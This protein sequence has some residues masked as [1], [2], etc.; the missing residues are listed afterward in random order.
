M[1]L[2]E[3]Y[4]IKFPKA[5]LW[6]DQVPLFF[7]KDLK[8]SINEVT[9]ETKTLTEFDKGESQTITLE[10]DGFVMGE[11]RD[12]LI[13]K[14]PNACSYFKSKKAKLVVYYGRTDWMGEGGE[15]QG[16]QVED[17]GDMF[18]WWRVEDIG[19]FNGILINI[20]NYET[21][22][23]KIDLDV[24]DKYFDKESKDRNLNIPVAKLILTFN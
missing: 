7:H 9:Y 13:E 1:D 19:L 20:K 14:Y 8:G 18:L 11:L 24:A 4:Q 17:G 22:N 21:V 16:L 23:L 12:W 6:I 5:K 3:P 10:L 15:P 2:N